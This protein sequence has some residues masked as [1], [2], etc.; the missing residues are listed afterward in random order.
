[1]IAVVDLGISNLGSMVN[2]LRQVDADFAVGNQLSLLQKAN[3]LVL[4]GVGSFDAGMKALRE[5]PHVLAVLEE[6][7][8][9]QGV[10]VLGVCLGMQ[11]MMRSSEEGAEQGLGW[12]EGEVRRFPRV[13]GLRVP[14]MGWNSV[15]V[16]SPSGLTSGVEEGTRFYFVHSYFVEMDNPESV[17]LTADYGL[18]FA[19]AVREG[20]LYGVQFHPEKSHRFGMRLLRNFVE[21]ASC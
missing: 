12:M 2:M 9:G 11:L 16:A 5:S 18:T 14:H 19:A 10:P 15:R 3:A 13:E 21:V 1:M 4:P 17:S 6:K 7:A 8:L 20:N